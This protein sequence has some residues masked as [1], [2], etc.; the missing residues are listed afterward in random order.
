VEAVA[1][2]HRPRNEYAYSEDGHTVQIQLRAKKDD[3]TL[4][5]IF[6]YDK[7][8]E[9]FSPII[10]PMQPVACDDLF[11]Y[12]R[13]TLTPPY[14]RLA[15]YFHL[16][17]KDGQSYWLDECGVSLSDSQCI[18]N[19]FQVPYLNPE[20]TIRVPEWAKSAIFYQIFPDSFARSKA[21]EDSGLPVWGSEPHLTKHLGGNFQG[22]IE[23]MDYLVSLGINAIYFCPIFKSNTCH[24]YNT[25][26]YSQISPMLGTLKDFR[27]LLN[28]CHSKGIRVVLDAVFNHT[29]D[30]FFAF[31]DIV[32]NGSASPYKNWYYIHEFP[33]KVDHTYRYERFSFE[34]HMPKLN[35]ANPEV[36][37][38][39]LDIACYWTKMGIDGWRLDVANEV[40]L[41]FWRTFRKA[42]KA[43]NPDILIL[44]E[45][46]NDALPYM[47]GDMI[48]CSMN[49]PFS[50]ACEYFFLER[51]MDAEGFQNQIMRQHMRY[52]MPN[53]YA[54]YNL[55]GSH[56]TP[57]WLT[58]AGEDDARI[59]LSIVFQFF[60]VGMPAIYY[61]DEVGMLGEDFV[62]A[63]ACMNFSPDERGA[64]LLHLYRSLA[65]LRSHSMALTTGSFCWLIPSFKNG[66]DPICMRRK[67]HNE[68]Y[69]LIINNNDSTTQISFALD[70]LSL[71]DHM[72]EVAPMN[73]R[74]FKNN[75]EIVL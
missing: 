19:S 74:I 42:V 56:D 65:S 52:P 68:Q 61:G 75:E 24:R 32:K 66:S 2:Y 13:A 12:F 21:A 50:K 67:S 39:L 15:Y 64:R 18:A 10:T 51:R 36:Q 60:F 7:Y 3:L 58:L 44:G 17:D 59:I 14:R 33:V 40:N 62:K 41:D 53:A 46:W 38:Y 6:Y 34:E 71:G 22:I 25:S 45:M 30:S 72:I 48:D 5:E 57:R 69:I 1:I 28:I 23:R 26:D 55:L 47:S 43:I 73:Y 9:L 20:D 16:I 37:A 63:R 27:D 49:Y 35:T 8:L 11:T 31:Q 29:C 4:A 54:M 70:D